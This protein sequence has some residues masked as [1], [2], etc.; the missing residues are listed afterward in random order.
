MESNIIDIEGVSIT[1]I[2]KICHEKGDIYHALK[3]TED[4]FTE[5]SAFKKEEDTKTKA[6]I[7]DLVIFELYFHKLPIR[8]FER[9]LR[10]LTN[11]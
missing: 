6:I 3:S 7:I 9:I 1:P 5:D 10:K 8:L 4:S 11:T 2:K